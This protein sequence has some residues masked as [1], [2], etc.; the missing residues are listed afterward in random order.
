MVTPSAAAEQVFV[1][2]PGSGLTPG[3]APTGS[4]LVADSWLVSDGRARG[5]DLHR[6]R[7]LRSCADVGRVGEDV[8]AFWNAAIDHLPTSGDWFPRVEFSADALRLRVRQAPARGETVTVWVADVADPRK[9]PRCKGPDLTSL[10]ELRRVAEQH[11]AQEALLRAPSGVVVEAAN[12]SVLWW[13]QD[14]LCIPSPTLPTLP[15]ITTALIHDQ[16]RQ[17]GIPVAFRHSPVA[18]LQDRETWLVNAL[19]GI[20]PVREWIGS[21]V[22][23]GSARRAA[24]WQE[25]LSGLTTTMRNTI[26]Q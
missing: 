12:S 8:A 23:P 9:Q 15:G 13:E 7:F 11:G 2:Q 16:A 10:A 22:R 25:W 21:T 26:R 5:L 6:Q 4:P 19:H 24:D 14:T 3:A 20:R 18:N 17:R 1:W